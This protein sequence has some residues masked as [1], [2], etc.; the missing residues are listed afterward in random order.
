MFQ[1]HYCT[2]LKWISVHTVTSQHWPLRKLI[3]G[4]IRKVQTCKYIVPTL[5]LSN[6][7]SKQEMKFLQLN[8]GSFVIL[9]SPWQLRRGVLQCYDAKA[10]LPVFKRN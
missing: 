6:I 8:W 9:S 2:Y 7:I 4:D 3:E 10:P 1:T 5:P